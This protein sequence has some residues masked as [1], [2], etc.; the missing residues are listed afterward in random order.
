MI[1]E[2]ESTTKKRVRIYEEDDASMTSQ[3]TSNHVI[4]RASKASVE[5]METDEQTM[6]SSRGS[7]KS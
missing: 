4:V 2:D 5:G 7:Q 6:N 3:K 1:E